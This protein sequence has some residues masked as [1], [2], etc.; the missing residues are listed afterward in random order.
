MARKI[1]KRYVSALTIAGSDS[2]GGAGIQADLKTFSAFGIYGASVIT[3]ITAQN[4][5]GVN[6]IEKVSGYMVREQIDAVFNDLTIDVLKT[7][8][9]P[10]VDIIEIV[11]EAIDR[12]HPPYVIVD[13]VLEASSRDQLVDAKVSEA[14][15]RC[16]YPRLTLLTPNVP[17]AAVLAGMEIKSTR[18][19]EQAGDVLI[20]QGCRAVLIKGGHAFTVGTIDTLFR[21]FQSTLYYSGPRLRTRNT[22]GTGCTLSAAIASCLASELTLEDS[23]EQAKE[24]MTAAIRHGGEIQT[25]W[26]NGPV[27]HFFSPRIA[28]MREIY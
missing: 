2:S 13:P 24:Y 18:D 5:S 27:S 22:H 26:G 19:I 17:E 9:L 7:G 20:R 28:L 14:Y 1:V 25:G 23:V 3:A 10:G 4:T 11:A 8:M 6:A 12:Y 16:L 21:S 15:R